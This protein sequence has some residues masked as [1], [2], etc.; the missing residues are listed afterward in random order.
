MSGLA[1][2]RHVTYFPKQVFV[3]IKRPGM[4]PQ[5]VGHVFICEGN[6]FGGSPTFDPRSLV[7]LVVFTR[8]KSSSE[9][10]SIATAASSPE[11]G[12]FMR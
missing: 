9:C 3:K 6:P 12:G 8:S 10:M 11:F 5:A 1:P 2:C 7:S 4:G